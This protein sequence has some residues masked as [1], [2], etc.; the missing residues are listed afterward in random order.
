[1][2]PWQLVEVGMIHFSV[3]ACTTLPS[4]LPSDLF[5][6]SRNRTELCEF[7]LFPP[8]ELAMGT[9]EGKSDLSLP[10][11]LGAVREEVRGVVT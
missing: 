4:V 9:M 7:C 2:G 6:C 5:L 10:V 8:M 11:F 1:M 3:K